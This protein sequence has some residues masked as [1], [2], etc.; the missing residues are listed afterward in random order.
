MLNRPFDLDDGGDMGLPFCSPD[1]RLGVEHRDSAGI[2]AVALLGVHALRG[3][4]RLGGGAGGLDFVAECRL[5]VLD[6]DDQM[7]FGGG[8][9]LESS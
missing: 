3:R 7:G 6:L 5:I 2:V 1:G 9:G 4:Q 8:G